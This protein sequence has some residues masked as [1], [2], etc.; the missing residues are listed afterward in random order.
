MNRERV[1]MAV[2]YDM[3]MVIGG[4]VNLRPLLTKT[5]QRLLY[6]TSFPAGAVFLDLPPAGEEP[7]VP[8]RLELALG[9]FELARHAGAS[10]DLPAAFASGPASLL[11][12]PD[13]IN[14]LPCR[15]GRYRVCLRLP[16]DSG[17]MILLFA[18]ELPDS[19]LPIEHIFQP[20][21]A[22]LARAILLCRHNEAYTNTL[23]SDRDLA[24]SGLA[25]FRAALDFSA[26]S[27]FL[28]DPL[29]MTFLDFNRSAEAQTGYAKSDLLAMGPLDL[30]LAL[31]RKRVV[32]L[33]RELLAT[34]DEGI[35]LD[36]TIRRQDGSDFLANIKLNLFISAAGERSVIAVARDITERHQAEAISNLFHEVDRRLL[37]RHAPDEIPTYVCERLAEAF[38]YPLVWLAAKEID[39]LVSFRASAGSAIAYLNGLQVRWDDTP[40]GHG[41]T[42]TAIQSRSSQA[43]HPGRPHYAAWLQRAKGFGIHASI[44]L[45]VMVHGEVFG[46]LNLY[47]ARP[48]AF[49]PKSIQRLEDVA[50]RVG[51]VLQIALDQQRLLLQGTAM[52]STANAIFITDREGLIEW[53]NPAFTRLSGQI[54][55]AHV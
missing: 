28:I 17:G 26:D 14:T 35:E 12:E 8:A 31:E 2:L 34:P 36:A 50:A 5:L 48:D 49:G 3:A 32:A 24:Q 46:A 13:L 18:P 6:H 44:A 38:G 9:D 55:R 39:G 43:C 47:A 40:D 45:P 10:L 41:A 11:D 51:I 33:F 7:A 42:G 23:I 52:E 54:G 4:E 25:R 1:I 53:V 29:T 16:I 22:N 27:V 20:V 30:M 15:H 19:D 37:E 21:M